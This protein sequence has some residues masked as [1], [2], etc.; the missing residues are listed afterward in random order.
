[1]IR[2]LL[3]LLPLAACAP[4]GPDPRGVA[5]DET[6][7]VVTA[8][9]RNETRPDEA[10]LSLGVTSRAATSEAASADNAAKMRRVTEA[11][12]GFGVR[13]DDLQT[14]NLQL[15]RIGYGPERGRYQAENVV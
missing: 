7:L 9:G 12:A 13:P 4:A 5:R 11:L 10:R 2:M 8:S 14:R 6:L 3:M 1:M 15:Q